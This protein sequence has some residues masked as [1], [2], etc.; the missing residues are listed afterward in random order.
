M[1][2]MG[3][4]IAVPEDI[5]EQAISALH[6]RTHDKLV[7]RGKAEQELRDAMVKMF[8]DGDDRAK[9]L[10]TLITTLVSTSDHWAY[11]REVENT[12]DRALAVVRYPEQARFR[13]RTEG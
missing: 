9:L 1:A 8:P 4:L 7:L 12:M 10:G 5:V 11:C 3:K 6:S 13:N 2:D